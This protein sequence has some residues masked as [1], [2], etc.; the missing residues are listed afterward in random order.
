MEENE[1]DDI[2]KVVL[3]GESGVGKT[4]IIGRFF[5][6]TFEESLMSTNG[7]SYVNRNLTF[8]EYGNRVVR[9]EIWDTAGQ[10]QYRSLNQIFYKD[11]SICIL[12]YDITNIKSFNALRDYWI[13]EIKES[14]SNK[15]I[16][17]L[18]AN[19]SDLD[20]KEQVEEKIAR[21][22]A[23]EINA[24]FMYTSAARNIGIDELFHNVGC[25][26]ID[27]N[28]KA[29]QASINDDAKNNISENDSNKEKKNKKNKKNKKIKLEE[30]NNK[31]GDKKKKCC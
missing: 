7:A 30:K 19:K 29:D 5:N 11:A 24:I 21:D 14:C 22:F 23:S 18:A 25:K 26:Y 10:E 4:S 27:P 31:K 13:K 2:C 1:E 28:F 9:F 3:I 20:E 8:S 16:L 15:I 6:G 17:G 12:V